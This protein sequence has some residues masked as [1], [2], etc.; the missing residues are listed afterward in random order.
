[1]NWGRRL[2]GAIGMGF[3]WAFAWFA[4][5]MVIE[6]IQNFV[7]GWNGAIVDIWPAALALPAFVGGVA[8]SG[9]LAIAGRNRRFDEMSLPRFAAW[10]A[11]GGI[12]VGLVPAAM[13]LAGLASVNPPATLRGITAVFAP[14]SM[15]LCSASASGSLMLARMAEEGAPLRHITRP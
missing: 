1:M 7:P 15:L 8:F 13:V 14:L 4:V 2:R 9:V 5:G 3:T 6:F 12:L 10:G 11:I